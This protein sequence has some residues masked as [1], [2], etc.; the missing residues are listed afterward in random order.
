MIRWNREKTVRNR[1]LNRDAPNGKPRNTLA[2]RNAPKPE[3][4]V[5]TR[6]GSLIIRQNRRDDSEHNPQFQAHGRL[7]AGCPLNVPLIK[8]TGRPVRLP[9]WPHAFQGFLRRAWTQVIS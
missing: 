8:R 5:R 1:K 6:L 4:V 7:D 3:S 9:F 2:H